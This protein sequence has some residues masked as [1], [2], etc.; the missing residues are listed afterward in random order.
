MT[1]DVTSGHEATCGRAFA[2]SASISLQL[3]HERLGHMNIAQVKRAVGSDAVTGQ[4]IAG[5]DLV[6][7]IT[8]NKT[9]QTRGSFPP[10][11]SRATKPLEIIHMDTIGPVQTM[12]FDSSW[13]A[14][15]VMYDFSSYTTVLCVKTKDQIAERIINLP[16]FWQ[17]QTGHQVLCI[18]SDHG[19]E[20]K[21]ELDV[22]CVAHGVHR[23]YSAVYTPEQNGRA[24]RANRD[25][26]EGA[27]ALLFQRDCPVKFWPFAMEAR[28]YIKNRV[29]AAGKPCA[30]LTAMFPGQV[31]DLSELRVFFC[32]FAVPAY[33][34]PSQSVGA[35]LT[36]SVCLEYMLAAAP[37]PKGGLW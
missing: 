34:S 6:S 17:R 31:P 20:F 28:A 29:P 27:R 3:A 16:V 23:Q 13:Y 11:T 21:G 9:K 32:V 25:E 15:P 35:S 30:P 18:R 37:A 5:G 33:P 24:E 2:A 14:V 19:T 26:I 4:R 12:G 1:F 8:C 7:C 36:Q 10:S 22:W